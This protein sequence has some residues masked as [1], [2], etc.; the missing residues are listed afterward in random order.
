MICRAMLMMSSVTQVLKNFFK[1]VK[2][3]NL[4]LKPSKF[5]IGFDKVNFEHKTSEN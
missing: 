1:K 3:A 2:G 5:K 4:S